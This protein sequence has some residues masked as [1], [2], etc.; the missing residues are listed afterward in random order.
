MEDHA[1]REHPSD[2]AHE[3]LEVHYVGKASRSRTTVPTANPKLRAS[4]KKTGSKM[5]DN[6]FY[7]Q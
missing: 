7:Q 1:W 6:I 2:L 5:T 3:W 4:T